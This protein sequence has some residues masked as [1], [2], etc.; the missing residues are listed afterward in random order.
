MITDKDMTEFYKVITKELGNSYVNYAASYAA[1][2]N[3]A[4]TR[5]YN[6][7]EREEIIVEAI[8]ATA[9]FHIA[10]GGEKNDWE[11][12]FHTCIAN[13]MKRQHMPKTKKPQTKLFFDE[14]VLIDK[15]YDEYKEVFF[16]Y[17]PTTE[18]EDF[19]KKVGEEI[20]LETVDKWVKERMRQ[21][22][23]VPID[24]SIF[25]VRHILGRTITEI[26]NH[27]GYSKSFV[28]MRCNNVKNYIKKEFDYESFD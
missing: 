27:L 15:K 8:I 17:H 7:T 18:I 1:K 28:R 13:I 3:K 4:T 25:R 21:G 22:K 20:S 9:S 2:K 14:N 12:Y 26:S 19:D 6:N 24:Y 5:L 16:D 11:R 23:I 10:K